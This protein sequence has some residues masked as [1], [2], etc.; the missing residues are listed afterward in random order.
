MK[1]VKK[2]VKKVKKTVEENVSLVLGKCVLLAGLAKVKAKAIA[3]AA[4]PPDPNRRINSAKR[5]A[6]Y[7]FREHNGHTMFVYGYPGLAVDIQVHG[8]KLDVTSPVSTPKQAETFIKK[9]SERQVKEIGELAAS[10]SKQW[11][12]SSAI[13]MFGNSA[14]RLKLK[15]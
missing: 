6:P 10:C 13:E 2:V 3:D 14:K 8:H 1:K 12:Q 15:K 9:V 5:P 11:R 4:C 7:T